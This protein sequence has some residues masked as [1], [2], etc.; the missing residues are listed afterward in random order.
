[1]PIYRLLITCCIHFTVTVNRSTIGLSIDFDN[2][3]GNTFPNL[4]GLCYVQSSNIPTTRHV[5][6]IFLT[7]A[8]NDK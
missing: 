1:M 6:H 3:L 7:D 2:P 8:N 5:G 4:S